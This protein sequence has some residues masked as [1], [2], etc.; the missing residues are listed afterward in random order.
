MGDS[1]WCPDCEHAA[2]RLVAELAESKRAHEQRDEIDACSNRRI[3]DRE[4]ERVELVAML[5][6][7]ADTSEEAAFVALFDDARALLARLKGGG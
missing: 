3:V 4:A 7:L 1:K 5:E 2:R 6:R